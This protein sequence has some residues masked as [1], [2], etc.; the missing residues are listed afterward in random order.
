M[1][2]WLKSQP[3]RTRAPGPSRA[4]SARAG[5]ERPDRG[6]AGKG[7]AAIPARRP[8]SA[9]G[10]HIAAP[11]DRKASATGPV[12]ALHTAGRPV[13][14]SRDYGA[15][16]RAGYME[17]PIVYRCVRMVA[18]AAASVKWQLFEGTREVPDHPVLA[19]LA[20]PNPLATGDD[21]LE[22][23]VGHLLV[24]GN[25][26]VEAV[27]FDDAPRELYALR[28]DRMKVVPDAS[29][30]PAAFE[31][32][33]NG[34]T[35]R[36]DQTTDGE[37]PVPPILHLTLF[38]PLDDHYGFP[39]L[40]AAQTSLDVHNTAA[41]WNKALLDNAARPSG[42]LVYEGRDGANLSEDQ[43]HRLKDEL[44]AGFQGAANAGRPLLLEGGLVWQAMSLSPRD[45]DFH[46][47]RNA[48]AREIALAFGVPPMLLG[49]PGDNTY[50]NYA[51]ANRA[52]W[53]QTVLPL[54]ARLARALGPWLAPAYAG[55]GDAAAPLR[56]WYDEDAISALSLE[57]ESLWKR[58]DTARFLTRD[59]KRAAAGY[60]PLDPDTGAPPP[61]A[62]P[63][64]DAEPQDG[65][66]SAAPGGA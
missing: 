23:L 25:A 21:F 49:I 9:T 15:L 62:G 50:A 12:V 22:S 10:V 42:A 65:P 54:V 40:A 36:F 66:Q 57:R 59:E 1:L 30:W 53:R 52:L 3:G 11:P 7:R 13:W 35:V 20:R 58:L 60:G 6:T 2:N 55:G 46:E 45:M 32:A 24:A 39:P 8:A 4:A 38:H 31:Y 47:A 48:A 41:A 17:N 16:A 64:P 29:G 26:Y 28:P 51:E 18:S 27:S 43:F 44:E 5:Q 61:V 33:A 56:L 37:H 34:R 19:L 63:A 14:T